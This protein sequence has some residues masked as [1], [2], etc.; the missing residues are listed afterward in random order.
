M[1]K[2]KIE[3]LLELMAYVA[4]FP[5]PWAAKKKFIEECAADTCDETNLEEFTSWFTSEH[6]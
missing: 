5:M 3:H 2:N 1:D 4:N 6:E